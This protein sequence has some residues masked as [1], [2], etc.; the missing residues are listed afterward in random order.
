MQVTRTFCIALSQSSNLKWFL[1]FWKMLIVPFKC[2][3]NG[4]LYCSAFTTWNLSGTVD[5]FSDGMSYQKQEA[6]HLEYINTVFNNVLLIVGVVL[7]EQSAFHDFVTYSRISFIWLF[8]TY[9]R[10]AISVFTISTQ[11]ICKSCWCPAIVLSVEGGFDYAYKTCESYTNI[12]YTLD[13]G[14]LWNI[15]V[16]ISCNWQLLLA[17]TVS[18]HIIWNWSFSFFAF[19]R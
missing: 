18:V 2:S 8:R 19:Y 17:S 4:K 1:K 10:S 9:Q 5:D 7:A 15:H 16:R 11:L 14:A 3:I 12:K 6:L 13:K